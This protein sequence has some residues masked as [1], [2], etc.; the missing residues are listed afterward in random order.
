[1]ALTLPQFT[2]NDGE[3]HACGAHGGHVVGQRAVDQPITPQAA[4]GASHGLRQ[5]GLRLVMIRAIEQQQMWRR[6][7][8]GQA[9]AGLDNHT[10]KG[11][12]AV[13]R[14]AGDVAVAVPQ[15]TEQH[16]GTVGRFPPQLHGLIAQTPAQH[17][18]LQPKTAQDLR[19]L[20]DVPEEVRG[21]ADVHTRA[22]AT[23]RLSP[24]QQVTHQGLGADQKLIGQ[25]VPGAD[26]QT[27]GLY[28]ATEVFFF[29][30]PHRQ[31]VL[32]DDGLAVEHEMAVVRVAVQQAEQ[33]VHQRHQP[34][35][36]LLESQIPFPVPVGV[37]DEV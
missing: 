28:K 21:I 1:M 32:D 4:G 3:V 7:V 33:F 37:R 27:A 36:K 23:G 34:Q 19:Q 25:D 14:Q 15:I 13:H 2:P 17:G 8:R 6:R 22:K 35:P 12:G 20:P 26:E 11:L 5:A 31:I 24:Q 10:G 16:A 30:R 18:A 9:I 29:L